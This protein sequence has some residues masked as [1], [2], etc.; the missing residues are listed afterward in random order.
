MSDLKLRNILGLVES[1]P[2]PAITEEEKKVEIAVRFD[3]WNAVI[4]VKIC[5]GKNFSVSNG[6]FPSLIFPLVGDG[7]WLGE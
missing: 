1:I 4:L 2:L 6:F 5:Y 3:F 7:F